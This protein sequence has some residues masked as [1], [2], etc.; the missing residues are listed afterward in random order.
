MKII[1]HRGNLNGPDP[2]TE[3]SPTQIDLCISKEYDVE[4]DLWVNDG[5]LWLGHDKPEYPI[6]KTWLT[7]RVRNLWVHCKNIEAIYYLKQECPQINYFWHQQDDYTLTSHG[8][9]WAYPDQPVP[10]KDPDVAFGQRSVCVMPELHNSDPSNFNAIC[11]DYP[12]RYK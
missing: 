7:F 5:E 9:V 12:E 10:K 3:N 4:V 2:L 8:W 1:S 11:T 6:S